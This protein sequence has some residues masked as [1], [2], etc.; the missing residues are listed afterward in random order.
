MLE[1]FSLDITFLYWRA[2]NNKYCTVIDLYFF[3]A[4]SLA[5][6]MNSEACLKNLVNFQIGKLT[7]FAYFWQCVKLL[8][9]S[10]NAKMRGCYAKCVQVVRS[11]MERLEGRRQKKINRVQ[12][13]ENLVD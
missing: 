5:V 10:F 12:R 1:S 8:A 2:K 6:C 11:A 13:E 9:V 4:G 3:L 7:R